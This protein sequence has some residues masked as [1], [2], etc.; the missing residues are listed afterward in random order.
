MLFHTP[1]HAATVSPIDFRSTSIDA[2]DKNRHPLTPQTRPEIVF[3]SPEA[4]EDFSILATLNT[5]K[6]RFS[7]SAHRPYVRATSGQRQ[8]LRNRRLNAPSQKDRNYTHACKDD[9]L[10]AIIVWF[11]H[12]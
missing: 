6:I 11:H 1:A 10:S 5:G 3:P 9:T 12:N 4:S 8:S 2:H 7:T